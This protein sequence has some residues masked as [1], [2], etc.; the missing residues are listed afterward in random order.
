M[1]TCVEDHVNQNWFSPKTRNTALLE[2]EIVNVNTVGDSSPVSGR[3]S[4]FQLVISFRH[5]MGSLLRKELQILHYKFELR[6]C[7][8]CTSVGSSFLLEPL[9]SLLHR[10][11]T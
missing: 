1:P 9:C 6:S 7:C 10:H 3:H 8:D 5:V 11:Q 2:D 4:A